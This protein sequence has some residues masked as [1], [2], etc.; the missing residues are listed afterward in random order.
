MNLFL[1]DSG[2]VVWMLLAFSIVFI[3]L[4]KFGWPIILQSLNNREQYITDSLQ[5]ADEAV[6]ALAGLE[7]KG[8]DIIASAQA[9]QLRMVKET[10]AISEK[11]IQEAKLQAQTEADKIIAS[12][13]EQIRKDKEKAL[14]DIRKEVVSLSIGMAEKVLRKELD[15]PKSQSDYIERLLNDNSLS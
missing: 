12:A 3:V 6:K 4:A 8:K 15:N 14:Q 13:Q 2:L 1:P 10:Q 7:Q 9:E 5:K 11:M